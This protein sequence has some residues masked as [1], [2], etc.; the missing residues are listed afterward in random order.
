MEVEMIESGRG[1]GRL[2]GGQGQSTWD[3][4]LG[5][6]A[7]AGVMACLLLGV[8]LG[9][10]GQELDAQVQR[11][12]TTGRLGNAKVGVSMVDVS[13]GRTLASIRADEPHIPASNQKIL[14]SGAALLVLGSDFT[15]R[16]EVLVRGRTLVLKGAGDPAFG[17]P[18]LLGEVGGEPL[19]V[20]RLL[21]LLAEAT[22]KAGVDQI[23]EIV[24]DDRIFDREFVHATWPIDQLNRW[25]C[26]EV[27]GLN[28]HTNVIN[29]F[30]TPTSIGEAPRVRM[31]PSSPWLEIQNS[32]RTVAKG[33]NTTWVARAQ[34]TNRFTLFGD[35]RFPSQVPVEVTVHDVPLYVGRLFAGALLRANVGV[36]GRTGAGEWTGAIDAVRRAAEG[37]TFGDARTVAVVTTHLSDILKRC[38]NDS[39]NLYAEALIKRIG[40]EVTG[41]PGSWTN[42]AAVMRM[43]LSERL[44]P[45][46]AAGAVIADGSGM[47][48]GNLVS[49]STLVSFLSM[50]GRDPKVSDV[51]IQSMATVGDGTLTRRFRDTALTNNLFAKSGA[52]NGVRCLSGYLI[53]P[54][55]GRTVAFSVMCNDLQSGEPSI[56][57][58][59]L[60]EQVVK[61]ADEWLS[62]QVAI[63]PSALGG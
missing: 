16:T 7:R 41:E 37:E 35:V 21:D 39:Q 44:G 42:G 36:A 9:A 56:N 22:R 25:Y 31:Q 18:K 2:V 38:N 28:F 43:V 26:A 47:S 58:L 32:A 52:I 49:P 57:A 27:A 10:M 30:A 11:L 60:H 63:E 24:I 8:A 19:T 5:G 50:M 40:A 6:A 14:T 13:T 62:R 20:E 23:D 59:R 34:G 48:R 15:F 33:E 45:Q 51:F 3:G 54:T 29:V 46:A 53:S 4:L 61:V 1:N 12:I 55:T 17:D